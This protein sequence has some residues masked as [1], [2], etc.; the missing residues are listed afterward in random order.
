MRYIDCLKFIKVA[1]INKSSN[2]KYFTSR[3][4]SV[5]KRR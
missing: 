2:R 3:E 4:S 1:N 5:K